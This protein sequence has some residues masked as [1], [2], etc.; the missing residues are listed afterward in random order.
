MTWSGK[1]PKVLVTRKI[2]EKGL[3]LLRNRVE[4]DLW[5]YNDI[6]IPK[7]ELYARAPA[8][9][10]I[11]ALLSDSMDGA[12]F[13]RAPNLKVVSNYAVGYDNVQVDEAVKRNIVV[14]NTPDVLTE[15]TADLA[16][17]LILGASRRIGE[18]ERLIRKGEW[19]SWGPTLLL[20]QDVYGASLGIL[21]LG[22]IGKAVARR[23][24]GFSMKIF[25]TGRSREDDAETGSRWLPLE[26]LLAASD[27][28]SLH[29]PLNESTRH[30][31]NRETLNLM[32]PSA[33]L[34]NTGRGG[35][36]DQDAL[37]EALSAKRIAAAGLDVFDP[38]PFPAN[39]PLLSLENVLAL[40]H[41]GSASIAAREGMAVLAAQN[42]LAVLEGKEPPCQV[43]P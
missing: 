14:T 30:I 40:P 18:A 5:D 25:H 1:K 27:I 3:E 29:C 33:V 41:I 37:Y 31:I 36:V 28:V 8:L 26:E 32:K 13:C 22:R 6:P 34:V 43:A 12:F 7:E 35:L 4:L 21:G 42:L 20:G 17:A 19:K 9:D 24:G 38:E 23:A 16:F 2:P 39:H 15:A 11:I 10:G